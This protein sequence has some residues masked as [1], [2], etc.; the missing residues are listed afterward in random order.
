MQARCWDSGSEA[1]AADM[2]GGISHAICTLG[3]RMRHARNL[4]PTPS[5]APKASG[6]RSGESAN[7]AMATQLVPKLWADGIADL[8][9]WGLWRVGSSWVGSGGG[10][11]SL[12]MERRR[13]TLAP[14]L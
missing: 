9:G 6:A 11:P 1:N 12:A 8:V 4:A 3:M 2:C 10:I 14:R 13:A 5:P 7:R